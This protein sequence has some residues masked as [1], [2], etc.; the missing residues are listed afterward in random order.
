MEESTDEKITI[1]MVLM[2]FL[3]SNPI[4]K[5]EEISY[6]EMQYRLKVGTDIYSGKMKVPEVIPEAS[7]AYKCKG[8]LNQEEQAQTIFSILLD[9]EEEVKHVNNNDGNATYFTGDFPY[10]NGYALDFMGETV[11][12]FFRREEINQYWQVEA[13]VYTIDDNYKYS[14]NIT[15]VYHSPDVKWRET[16]EVKNTG[17]EKQI[18][19]L[20]DILKRI[21]INF[22]NIETLAYWDSETLSRNFEKIKSTNDKEGSLNM[23]ISPC[24]MVRMP[25]Y[26]NELPLQENSAWGG[27]NSNIVQPTCKIEAYATEER[28]IYFSITGNVG[29]LTP[30][31]DK[32]RLLTTEEIIKNYEVYLDKLLGVPDEM[33]SIACIRPE[34]RMWYEYKEGVFDPDI[35]LEPV[36]AIYGS[37]SF[38]YPFAVFDAFDGELISW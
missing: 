35:Y 2:L 23:G 8:D 4:A 7:T 13:S 19:T 5:A 25:V 37:Q 24:I 10:K 1:I 6:N 11:N 27:V 16:P 15:R 20:F 30:I 18:E 31:S 22:G 29:N 28:L 34:Y 3:A 17:F 14:D 26:I 33:K 32:R 9:S 38:D 21:G 36:W 12:Y